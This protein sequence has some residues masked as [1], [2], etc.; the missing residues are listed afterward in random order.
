MLRL[1]SVTSCLLALMIAGA[2]DVAAADEPAPTPPTTE[3]TSEPAPAP[4]APETATVRGRVLDNNTK[5]GLPAATIQIKGGPNGDH[6]LVAELDGGY[7][8]SLAPGSYTIVFST[9]EYVDQ[10]RS[11]T[12]VASQSLDLSLNLD[13]VAIS[14]T[15]ETIEV[16]GTIDTRKESAVLAVRRA[17]P[18]VSDAVGSQEIARTLDSN[19]GDAVK[20]VVAVTVTD[21]KYVALRGLEGRYVTTLLNGVLLP[22]PEP[23]RNAIPLDLFPTSLLSTMTVMKSYSAELPAQFGGGTLSIDTSS[24][25]TSFEMKL[26]LSSSATTVATG[27]QGLTN[28]NSSGF[29]NFLGFDGGQRAL[30]D[31]VPRN[32]AVRGMTAAQTEA[33]GESMPKV[34]TPRGETVTP[35]LGLTAMVG[36][37]T[38]LFGKRVGYLATGMVRRSF[39]VREGESG[40]VALV[41]GE[42]M[43]TETLDYRVGT[44]EATV[45]GLANVGIDLSPNHEVSALGLYTH[46]GEDT[47]SMAAGYSE[48]DGSDIGVSRL[49]FVER[50]L[51]FG[52]LRGKHHLSRANR[53]ELHWQGNVAMTTRDEL[54]SRDLIYTIDPISGQRQY[55]DQPGSGQHFWQA[56]DD[57]AGG[58]GTDL[59]CG[60]DR[61]TSTSA[62]SGSGRAASSAA[63]GS[64]TSTWATIPTCADWMASRCSPT[65]TSAGASSSRRERSTRMPT[66]RR[67]AC[68]ARTHR[69]SSSYTKSFARSLEPATS[70]RRRRCPTGRH[71]RSPDSRA[72]SSA[73]TVICC[74]QRTSCIRHAPT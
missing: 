73:P 23:D 14:G 37:T 6:T 44:A 27:Q 3:P 2:V 39:S 72:I 31:A 9:P 70:A 74:L 54:D 71:S 21:G 66:R 60:S 65:S 45:G 22:S 12:L 61:P 67:W 1:R 36:D 52:Q 8:F 47:S 42:L 64:A 41:G 59:K 4:A 55:K 63:V 51:A 58:G 48:A 26:G 68:S 30:P 25:P 40:R 29:G 20:R 43:Q 16:S 34:W 24:F 38:K 17:A 62:R 69:P 13:P 11:V 46:V 56:L 7:S 5:E 10:T 28:A 15:E 18:M 35:N 53:V 57:V 33:I 49:S 50:S 19:A 32:R